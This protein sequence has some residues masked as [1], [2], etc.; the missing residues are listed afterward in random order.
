MPCTTPAQVNTERGI[1]LAERTNIVLVGPM[2]AGKST[3]GR[4]LA[5]RLQMPFVDSDRELESRTGVDI[6][7]IFEYEGEEGFRR[8]EAAVLEDLCARCGIVL[9][10]GGGAVMRPENRE[11]LQ[12]CGLVV[13]LRTPVTLQLKRTARDRNRP[14]LQTEDP[15]ARLEA[16]L[17]VR[18]PLY[19]EVAHLIVDTDREHL[20]STVRLIARQYRNECAGNRPGTQPGK[21]RAPGARNNQKRKAARSGHRGA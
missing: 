19:R 4:H 2:G 8:R 3:V 9:A 5:A 17:E 11:Q 18:D 13:Y 20:R 10:T 21:G 15:R 14:L 6:P 12:R 7:T 16:L 1:P